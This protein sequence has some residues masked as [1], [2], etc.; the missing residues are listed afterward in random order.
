MGKIE[1]AFPELLGD[2]ELTY[3]LDLS[4]VLGLV[5]FQ[6]WWAKVVSVSK[7][8]EHW[9]NLFCLVCVGLFIDKRFS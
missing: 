2:L 4:G 1:L 3:D 7:I 6:F 8:C 9:Q 5:K